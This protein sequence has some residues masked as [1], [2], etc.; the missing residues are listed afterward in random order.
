MRAYPFQA[1]WNAVSGRAVLVCVFTAAGRLS[2]C[3]V[4]SE[5]PAGTSELTRFQMTLT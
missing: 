1:E 3:A 5:E 4:T 2:D